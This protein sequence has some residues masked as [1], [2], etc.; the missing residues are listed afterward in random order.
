ML[1][2]K[3]I[4]KKSVAVLL[5]GM[6]LSMFTPGLALAAPGLP[7]GGQIIVVIP[8]L[9]SLNLLI[10]Q[11]PIGA[12][13]PPLLIFD[14]GSILYAYY[15]IWVPGTY[16]LGDYSIPE[17]CIFYKGGDHPCIPIAIAPRIDYVG[18]SLN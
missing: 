1:K 3:A 7:F 4:L 6:T 11:R 10:V 13:S 16:L 14:L 12:L 15:N 2:I 5:L 18:T 9:C 17:P 8:C